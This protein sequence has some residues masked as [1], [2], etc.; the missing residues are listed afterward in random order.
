MDE[1]NNTKKIAIACQGGG[2]HTAFTAGVLKRLLREEEKQFEITVLSGTSGGAVC[3][4]LAWYGLLMKDKGKAIKLL[5]DFWRDTSASSYWD[6]VANNLFVSTHRMQEAGIIPEFSPYLYPPVPQDILRSLLNKHVK[7][8]EIR[9]LDSSGPKLFIGAVEVHSGE[10]KVFQTDGYKNEISADVILA[11]AAVPTFL[12][13]V[14]IENKTY[15]DGQ[16]PPIKEFITGNAEEKPDEIWIIQVYQEEREK[17][18]ESIKNIHERRDE[19]SG[20]LTLNQEITFIE[21]VNK[22]TKY[23]PHEKYKPIK[24]QKI[25]MS[26]NT[27][28]PASRHERNPTFIKKMMAYGDK[29]ADNFLKNWYVNA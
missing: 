22:W 3:A 1:N 2:S 24:V 6:M 13:A 17:V 11:S 9:K 8:E 18:P 4:L 29:E 10:F 7:F 19:I 27:L 21:A 14:H 23:L 16:N 25:Q 28:D 15:W 26:D 20:N 5:D 12:R